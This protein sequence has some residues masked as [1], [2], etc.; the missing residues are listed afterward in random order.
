MFKRLSLAMALILVL[1]FSGV[2]LA[3]T[4]ST[5]VSDRGV[6]PMLYQDGPGGNVE[7]SQVGNYMYSSPR[8]DNGYQYAWTYGP[9]TWSTTDNTYLSWSGVHDGMAVILKGGP[10][11]NVYTY[12]ASYTYDSGLASPPVG[13]Q[14]NPAELSNLT[15]CWNPAPPVCSYE[16]AWSAGPRYVTR[17]NWATYTPYAEDSTVTLFAGQTMAAGTVH[18]S[19]PDVDGNVTITIAFN[20]GWGL[21]A[22]ATEAVK[23]QGYDSVPSGNPAPG[24]FTTYKGNLLTVTVPQYAYYG[25]HVD[26]QYCPMP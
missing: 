8:F 2:A 12:D 5:P 1:A 6:V 13:A 14:Q 26:V 9:F 3:Q 21:N 16:T 22:G 18:F 4:A 20:A 19:A 25:V 15:F 10:G 17:G 7:C 24:L 23:I 11:A